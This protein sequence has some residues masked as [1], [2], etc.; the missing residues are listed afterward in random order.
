MSKGYH[1]R[2]TGKR[3][4]LRLL[5]IVCEG[6]RT[7]PTYFN[8]YRERGSG[9]K[10]KTLNC[11]DTDPV[12]LVEF[13]L[14]QIEKNDLD[15][16][17]GDEIWCVF[18][19]DSNSNDSLEKARRLAT[20]KVKI[21][22]SNPCFELWYFLHFAYSEGTLTKDQLVSELEEYLDEYDP[23]K[24]YFDKLLPVRSAAIKNSA[25][26]VKK[27]IDAGTALM[28]RASNP[29]TQIGDLVRFILEFEKQGAP[30]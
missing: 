14:R 18:D 20:G 25:K 30:R 2:K 1:A 21:A 8:R 9:L 4:P 5:I 26:L 6:S 11:G 3:K 12:N 23:V 7:E 10:I 19:V 17:G 15:L 28:S 24:D 27:H 22:L 13:A 16:S 29:S